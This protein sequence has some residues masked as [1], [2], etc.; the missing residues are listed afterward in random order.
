MKYRYLLQNQAGFLQRGYGPQSSLRIFTEHYDEKLQ[1]VI[2]T[3]VDRDDGV[4][5][6]R[7]VQVH[8]PGNRL[9][10]KR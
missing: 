7:V 4:E 10:F 6:K 5:E 2:L 9:Q 8:S 3:A 1:E